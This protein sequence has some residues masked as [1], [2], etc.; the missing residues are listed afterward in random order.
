MKVFV[1]AF[2]L[3]FLN[4][5]CAQESFDKINDSYETFLERITAKDTLIKNRTKYYKCAEDLSGR[6]ELYYLDDELRLMTHIYKQGFGNDT[7]LENYF[8]E[9]DVLRLKTSIS[10][11]MYMNTLYKESSQGVSSTSAEKVVEVTE[12]RMY[13][14]NNEKSKC[15]ERKHSEKLADWD[16][17]Y[18]NTLTLKKG[19]CIEGVEDIRYKYRLLRKAEKKLDNYS[20][21]KP[22]CIF[23]IW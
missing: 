12:Q 19:I 20:N 5:M 10:E 6:I 4:F 2:L 1:S 22:R 8:I 13:F 3:F 21:R 7:F 18:F 16:Q 9:E 11:I 15:F 17:Q 14:E 23:H